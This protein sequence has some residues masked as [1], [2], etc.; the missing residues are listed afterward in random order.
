MCLCVVACVCACVWLRVCVFL[1]SFLC[2][3]FFPLSGFPTGKNKNKNKNKK[4]QVGERTLEVSSDS[5]E[6]ARSDEQ[7]GATQQQVPVLAWSAFLLSLLPIHRAECMVDEAALRRQLVSN[8][9]RHQ[10]HHFEHLCRYQHHVFHHWRF[11]RVLQNAQQ[12]VAGEQGQLNM[13]VLLLCRLVNLKDA[14]PKEMLRKAVPV[15]AT[16]ARYATRHL[17]A[18]CPLFFREDF[19]ACLQAMSRAVH[20]QIQQEQNPN[21][22]LAVSSVLRSTVSAVCSGVQTVPLWLLSAA[23]LHDL[24]IA[25]QRRASILS[26]SAATLAPVA[27]QRDVLFIHAPADV[28][29]ATYQVKDGMMTCVNVTVYVRVC[30]CACVRV[31]TCVC[32]CVYMCVCAC[33]RV[34]V[35]ACVCALSRWLNETDS[36][37]LGA[38][39]FF[40]LGFFCVCC[41]C[42]NSKKR[43]FVNVAIRVT[44]HLRGV[45][46]PSSVKCTVIA[47]QV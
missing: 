37:L 31:C 38:C 22:V 23:R 41:A 17:E 12:I 47:T 20:T 4:I 16:Y 2:S 46:L 45:V 8:G 26:N 30:V 1:H 28:T 14:V 18:S 32:A 40:F 19:V 3:F 42:R 7:D 27:A 33:V 25:A 9:F 24:V 43:P 29:E 36:C 5:D 15:A 6:A 21:T 44:P 39:I 10:H 13:S 11:L 35:C 34:C